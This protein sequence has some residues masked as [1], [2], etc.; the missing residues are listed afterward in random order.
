MESCREFESLI[1]RARAEELP[2]HELEPLLA[3]LEACS[4]CS[5]LFDLLGELRAGAAPPEPAAGEL[6]TMRR[7]VL[8]ELAQPQD[9]PFAPRGGAPVAGRR[10]LALAA[11]I[12][13][14]LLA[15]G[16]WLG[17]NAM[18]QSDGGS[19]ARRLGIGGTGATGGTSDTR[20]LTGEI[21]A[22]AVQNRQFEDVENSLFLFS[23]VEVEEVSGGRLHLNFDVSRHLDLE[24]EKND[25]LV[26][27]ILVQSLIGAS[28]VGTRIRAV[29][30]AGSGAQPIDP[31]VERALLVAVRSDE[32]LGV[33]LLAQAKLAERAGDPAVHAA[34]L[35]IL[36]QEPSVQMR[37]AA[38]EFLTRD[39]IRPEDLER[40]IGSGPEPGENAV[41]QLAKSYLHRN[42]S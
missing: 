40:A 1:D 19:V 35:A 27:E 25:P 4:G 14:L 22:A 16:W 41:Y 9:R 31:K 10:A 28:S 34:M 33:R 11:G 42:D 3:H 5:E 24:L 32:N 7:A 12:V 20:R 36:E 17:R 37:L 30:L 2:E 29:G 15:G 21:R 8:A 38:I 26:T 23:N 13:F 18:G 39:H 6:T